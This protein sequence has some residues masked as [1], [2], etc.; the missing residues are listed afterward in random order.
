MDHET[1]MAEAIALARDAYAR[2]DWPSA[3]LIVKDGAVI[4][5]G[6]NSQNTRSDVTWH[7]ETAA[8]R[9][10]QTSLRTL[11]LAGTTLYATMEPC[12]MCAGAMH[13]AHIDRIV[14]ALRH[15]TIRRT[16]LGSY[17]L[18]SFGKLVGWEFEL[19]T[20]VR[21]AEYLALRREWGQDR[22]R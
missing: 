22:T 1:Y 6:A 21:E 7:G 11:D 19:V 2:G 14:L 16:D 4:A 18:E 9:E 12:P 15:A 8:I 20:G 5:R 3:A 17:A 13:L 10:A